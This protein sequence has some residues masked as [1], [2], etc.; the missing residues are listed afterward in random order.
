MTF[1]S[2]RPR[3][4][5]ATL[6]LLLGAC[7]SAAPARTAGAPTA[8]PVDATPAGGECSVAPGTLVNVQS[9]DRTVRTDVRYATVNNF[10]GAVLPGYERPLAMLRPEAAR[11]LVRVHQALRE[12]GYGLKVFDG[13]RPV[14]A[15]LGMVDWAERTDNE[16][17]LEQGYVARQSGHNRGGT[18]DLTLVRLSDGR[19]VEMGTAYDT[20]SEAAH[21]AN[22]TGRIA[23]NR[24]I[25]VDAMRAEGFSNYEKEWW[26]FSFSG[27]YP[28][29]DVPLRCFR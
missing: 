12:R 7:A 26:H 16:W 14:R 29:L 11:A 22:A 4:L 1:S 20:F 6:A 2:P 17:V 19:E 23:E 9:L 15:T 5:A 8:A 21:T 24:R 13:Y 25:L 27:T 28:P 3:A 18:V 10:T